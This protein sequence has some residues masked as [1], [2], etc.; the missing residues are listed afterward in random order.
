MKESY[1]ITFSNSPVYHFSIA[2]CGNKS[3]HALG[4]LKLL[5]KIYY[6]NNFKNSPMTNKHYFTMVF[7]KCVKRDNSH[8]TNLD[9]NSHGLSYLPLIQHNMAI[10]DNIHWNTMTNHSLKYIEVYSLMVGLSRNGPGVFGIPDHNVCIRS[11]CYTALL[12]VSNF[13]VIWFL[14]IEHYGK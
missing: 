8:V 4:Y 1:Q 6:F 12:T 2:W 5:K 10:G 13:T 3:A 11:Y 14:S 9:Y 7:M